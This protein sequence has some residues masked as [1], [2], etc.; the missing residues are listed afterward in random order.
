M[1]LMSTLYD[2]YEV[3]LKKDNKKQIM[4]LKVSLDLNKA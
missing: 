3:K 4:T 2:F 1:L